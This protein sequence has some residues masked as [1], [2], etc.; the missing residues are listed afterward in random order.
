[1]AETDPDCMA[2]SLCGGRC[3]T[4][5]FCNCAAENDLAGLQKG[6]ARR[7]DNLFYN[8]IGVELLH[9]GPSYRHLEGHTLYDLPALD[10]S[11]HNDAAA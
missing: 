10:H 3:A 8:P 9:N 7:M 2:F 5:A 1:M 4:S 6:R 11:A